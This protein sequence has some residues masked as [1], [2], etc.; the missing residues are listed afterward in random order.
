MRHSKFH[1]FLSF[2]VAAATTVA[3]TAILLAFLIDREPKPD[4][5]DGWRPWMNSDIWRNLQT[6]GGIDV[7]F[8]Y[9]T[10]VCM[11]VLTAS[12]G[13]QH[14]VVV[15][16][17]SIGAVLLLFSGP[18][19]MVAVRPAVCLMLL[20]HWIR[21]SRILAARFRLLSRILLLCS[22]ALLL[23]ALDDPTIRQHSLSAW[24]YA[25]SVVTA[26]PT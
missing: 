8:L 6:I 23:L 4:V 5:I 1:S 12:T 21:Q 9:A 16:H 13:R 7:Y 3:E 26:A 2:C 14:F 24:E 10:A 18:P 22:L 11:A 17:G 20:Y 19:S 25:G 15:V